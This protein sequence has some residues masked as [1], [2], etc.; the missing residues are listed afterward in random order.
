MSKSQEDLINFVT[1]EETLKAAAKGSME[2][3][4][5]LISDT[6]SKDDELLEAM[7]N[8]SCEYGR[9]H[10]DTCDLNSENGAIDGCTCSVSYLLKELLPIIKQYGIQERI[11]ELEYIIE[12]RPTKQWLEHHLAILKEQAELTALKEG[13]Q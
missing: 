2:K 5:A 6:A 4:A 10:E 13:K 1:S 7:E 11:D 9:P 8:V 3:R 12:K